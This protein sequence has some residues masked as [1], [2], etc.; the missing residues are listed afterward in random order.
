V[1]VGERLVQNERTEVKSATVASK[2]NVIKGV[3]DLDLTVDD[4]QVATKRYDAQG[5]PTLELKEIK[6]L[7]GNLGAILD[8]PNP[9]EWDEAQY[10]SASVDRAEETINVLRRIEGRIQEYNTA[11]A[12]CRQTLA[13]VNNLAFQT[14]R[15]LKEIGDRLAE[16]RH[17]V[18]VAQALW[19]E[20]K[21]RVAAVNTRR[22]K[23]IAEQVTFLAF[24]RP[25]TS[26]ARQ[27]LPIRVLD[28]G[29]RQA[30]IPACRQRLVAVPSELRNLVNLL[31]NVPLKWIKR[32]PDLLNYLDRI[33][34]LQGVVKSA[35]QRAQFQLQTEAFT[36]LGAN[37]GV[38][39]QGLLG[40]ALQKVLRTQFQQVSRQQAIKSQLN[41]ATLAQLSWK[42][43]F[44]QAQEI[45]SLADLSDASHGHSQ[46]ASLA[47]ARLDEIA[48]VAG[49]LY[50]LFGKIPGDIRLLWAERL[51]QFDAPVDLRDLASL[52]RWGDETIDRLA[53][54]DMQELVDWLYD[55]IDRL[56][57]EAVAIMN[58]VVR[59]SILLASHAPVNQ[60]I[61]G[62][63]QQEAP[64]QVG[65][66]VKVTIPV[67]KVRIGMPAI[68]LS[69]DQQV[70]AEAIVDDVIGSQAVTRIVNKLA[71]AT[72][73]DV[74]AQVHFGNTVAHPTAG[75][76]SLMAQYVMK[77][78]A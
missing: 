59:V 31:R 71:A 43:T 48:H 25:R 69:A 47:S 58:D 67:E 14:D 49:C 75:H 52:P 24:R 23:I 36:L 5:R 57:S 51:S 30:P 77:R 17:D 18:A 54:H 37:N 61:A 1:T 68:L 39:E 41:L 63:V 15:R 2:F 6:D 34:L 38:A 20:E 40:G 16:A 70:I 11:I 65:G 13:D 56:Q 46:V 3:A 27:D 9:A 22:Q 10:F 8:D 4:L 73:I 35:S 64:V 42:E 66:R 19:D 21:A 53:R 50:E 55:S 33:D 60:I 44:Q 28:P 76:Q 29:L 78:N 26:E 7:R 12:R 32:A 72:K 62:R 45:V 74:N